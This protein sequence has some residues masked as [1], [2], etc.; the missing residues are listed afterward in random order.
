MI[1][2]ASEKLYTILLVILYQNS[3]AN[4]SAPIC[5]IFFSFSI[6]FFVFKITQSIFLTVVLHTSFKSI[7]NSL[8]HALVTQGVLQSDVYIHSP[9]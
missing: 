3:L 9:P 1:A 7:A 8:R 2:P 6:F 5:L 4:I